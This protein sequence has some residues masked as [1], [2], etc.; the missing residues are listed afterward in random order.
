M[1]DGRWILAT[2]GVAAIVVCQVAAHLL[3]VR[4]TSDHLLLLSPCAPAWLGQYLLLVRAARPVMAAAAA[5]GL[6][7]AGVTVAF[8]A[9]VWIFV[10]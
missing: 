4:F 8:C 9:G 10:L 6:G 7:V 2:V 1:T 3:L 5:T